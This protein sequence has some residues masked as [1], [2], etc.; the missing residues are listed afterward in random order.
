MFL[1]SGLLL[2]LVVLK[3]LLID[4]APVFVHV[5]PEPEPDVR[6]ADCPHILPEVRNLFH[7]KRH[8]TGTEGDLVHLHVVLGILVFAGRQLSSGRDALLLDQGLLW[9]GAVGHILW[10]LRLGT[11][12][13]VAGVLIPVTDC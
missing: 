10:V 6:M 5:V 11:I 9:R 3:P 12:K 2:D 1:V 8:V 13:P 4:V 7:V